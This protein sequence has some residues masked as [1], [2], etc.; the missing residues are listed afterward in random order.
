MGREGIALTL[1]TS[2]DMHVLR[3]LLQTKGIVP[4]WHGEVPN[5]AQAVKKPRGGRRRSSR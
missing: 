2:R 3:N 5:L 1:V 4:T